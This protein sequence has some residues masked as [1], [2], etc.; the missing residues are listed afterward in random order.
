M[1]SVKV[2][3]SFVL[4]GLIGTD[5]HFVTQRKLQTVAARFPSFLKEICIRFLKV[6]EVKSFLF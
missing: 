1:G 5:F 3:V 2:G 6:S 4:A